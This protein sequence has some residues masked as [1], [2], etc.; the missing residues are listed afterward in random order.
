MIS[1]GNYWVLLCFFA[2][3]VVLASGASVKSWI[4]DD[5]PSF[6]KRNSEEKTFMA[7]LGKAV[8]KAVHPTAQKIVMIKYEIVKVKDKEN[9]SEI[10]LKMEYFGVVSNKKYIGDAVIKVDTSS[11]EG[12]EALNIDYVD[13]NNLPLNRKNLQELIKSLNR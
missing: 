1:K 9:R 11:K 8:I 4:N 5:M 10:N 12:W 6:K 2:G 13:N 7:E 3:F